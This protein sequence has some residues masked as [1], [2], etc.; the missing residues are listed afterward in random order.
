MKVPPRGNKINGRSDADCLLP[1]YWIRRTALEMLRSS[2][3]QMDGCE[4]QS[5]GEGIFRGLDSTKRNRTG[6]SL[7]LARSSI[8]PNDECR[9]IF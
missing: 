5:I 1:I 7:D 8:H 2:S 4:A 9:E 3:R 6:S